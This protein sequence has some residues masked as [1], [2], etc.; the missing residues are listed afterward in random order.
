MTLRFFCIAQHG[1]IS[2]HTLRT[3]GDNAL[4]DVG[5]GVLQFLSTPSVRRVTFQLYHFGDHRPI[6]IHTLRTEGDASPASSATAFA[7][8]IH[9][10]R[11]EGDREQIANTDGIKPISIHTLRTEGDAKKK[12][13]T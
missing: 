5:L 13:L 8:S 2:I 9:T 4:V 10:L 1:L 3:E 6:S 7:I 12:R 11:T